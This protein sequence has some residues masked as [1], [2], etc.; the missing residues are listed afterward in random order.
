MCRLKSRARRSTQVQ[1]DYLGALSNTVTVPVTAVAPGLFTSDFSGTG[2]GFIVNPDGS[3]NSV[4]HPADRNSIVTLYATGTGQTTPVSFDGEIGGN[5]QPQ[6][7]VSVTI[8]GVPALVS[9]AGGGQTLVA[10]GLQINV[11]VPAGVAPGNAVPVLITVG[12]T[13][14]QTGVTMAVR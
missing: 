1:L 6:L 9:Y 4:A 14:S 8:G 12:T 2:Q 11:T 7:Q 3:I 10:G 5:A 13:G